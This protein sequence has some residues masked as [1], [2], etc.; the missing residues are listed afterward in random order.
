MNSLFKYFWT[1]TIDK[2]RK[3]RCDRCVAHSYDDNEDD[4]EVCLWDDED[5]YDSD[6]EESGSSLD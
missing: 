1:E 5:L 4:D 2:V 3:W 6:A